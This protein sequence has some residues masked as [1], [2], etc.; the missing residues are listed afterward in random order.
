LQPAG[1]AKLPANPDLAI[2]A[3]RNLCKHLLEPLQ[4]PSAAWRS[5]QPTIPRSQRF[6]NATPELR[7]NERD[8]AGTSGI[9][10]MPKEEWAR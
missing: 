1:H 7:L 5:A 8:L 3:G 9:N 2:E 4:Q 10:V 6:G